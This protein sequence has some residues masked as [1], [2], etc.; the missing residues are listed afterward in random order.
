MTN[1]AP[2]TVENSQTA[3]ITE[4]TRSDIPAIKSIV[5]AAYTKYLPRIGRPP[6]PM[7]ADYDELL[8][9]QQ[10]YVLKAG[11][12]VVGSIILSRGEDSDSIKVNNLVVDP[13]AQGRGYGRLLMS[14]AESL[15]RQQGLA[16]ITL[17]TNLKMYEN[18]AL[19]G[20]LGLVE[21]GRRTE[22]SYERVYFRKEFR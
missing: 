9:T 8:S 15:A 7:L 19:Y 2:Q 10:V 17:F 13:V 21:T 1:N 4:A 14:H 11:T 5:N 22:D 18:I 16:A 3:T 12:R 20:K 6:A